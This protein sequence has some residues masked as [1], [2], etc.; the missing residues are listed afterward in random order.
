VSNSDVFKIYTI[1]FPFLGTLEA[2]VRPVIMVSLPQGKHNVI[3][4]IPLSS[5]PKQ[6]AVD[7]ILSHWENEGLIKPSVARVHRIT[8]MLQSDLLT[9]LGQL[10]ESDIKAL[11]ESMRTYLNI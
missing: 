7:V 1:Q 10:V 9:E 3:A 11:K 2:K 6:E 4:V 5:K 8:T